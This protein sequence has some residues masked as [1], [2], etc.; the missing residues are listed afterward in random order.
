MNC[1]GK[2]SPRGRGQGEGRPVDVAG[3]ETNPSP[4]SCLAGRGSR[5]RGELVVVSSIS[6]AVRAWK[7]RPLSSSPLLARWKKSCLI[8]LSWRRPLPPAK[9]PQTS[10]VKAKFRYKRPPL[11]NPLLQRSRGN[12]R[13][14]PVT[15]LRCHCNSIVTDKFRYKRPPLPGPLLQRR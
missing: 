11:P 7:M 12:Q 1:F 5:E 13:S 3:A 9:L 15:K 4:H 6:S 2:I 14:R 8:R 10:I